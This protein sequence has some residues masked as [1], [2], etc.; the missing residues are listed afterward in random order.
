MVIWNWFEGRWHIST[1]G[2]IRRYHSN[3]RS[4]Y[5]FISS[6]LLPHGSVDLGCVPTNCGRL[7]RSNLWKM[8]NMV[9]VADYGIAAINHTTHSLKEKIC[10]SSH[11]IKISKISLH[12]IEN[13][14]ANVIWTTY[15]QSE[16]N[17]SC[18]CIFPVFI[19]VPWIAGGELWNFWRLAPSYFHPPHS[20]HGL[21]SIGTL[22]QIEKDILAWQR[23]CIWLNR[24]NS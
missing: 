11:A 15:Y 12:V 2:W 9:I 13:G 3:R 22:L 8:L 19:F 7:W 21:V 24:T 20:W 5:L 6:I 23:P 18:F 16:P 14:R 10:R 17:N 4:G 1:T